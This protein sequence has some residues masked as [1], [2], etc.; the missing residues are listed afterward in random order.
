V[1]NTNLNKVNTG[2]KI[3]INARKFLKKKNLDYSHGTGHGVGFYLNVH[4]GPQSISK[5]NNIPLKPGMVL[6]N[7]PGYYEEN[8]FGMRIE[9]LIYV[10]KIKKNIFFENLT[11]APIDLDLVDFKFLDK[12][13]KKYLNKYHL[14]TYNKLAKYLNHKEK[15]W[16]LNLI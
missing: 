12:N 7:E 5:F 1:I 10:K 14:Q 6:S 16:L 8:K 11:F 3:D 15:K 9:N 13:E 2:K 4:E